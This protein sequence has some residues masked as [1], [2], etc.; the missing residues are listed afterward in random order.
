MER[1]ARILERPELEVVGDELPQPVVRNQVVARPEEGEKPVNG[2]SGKTFPL[3]TPR[4]IS[5]SSSAVAGVGGREAMN[6]PLS[7]PTEVPTIRSGI[8]SR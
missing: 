6:A 3:P 8:T 1:D 5:A 4:Q 7:A 2:L